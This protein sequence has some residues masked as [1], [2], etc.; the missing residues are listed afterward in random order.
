MKGID[1]LRDLFDE[2]IITIINTFLENPDNPLSLTE[3]SKESGVNV[4]TAL[5]IID[6][7]INKDFVETITIGKSK[8]YKLK[9]SE[10]TLGLYKLLRKDEGLSNFIDKIKQDK[11]IKKIILESKTEKGAKLIIVGSEI[12]TD[13]ILTTA[14]KI[15]RDSKFNIDFIEISEKQFKEMERMGLYNLNKKIV[16]ERA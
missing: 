16:W 4:A 14:N 8:A 1:I 6:K 7:L 10:K 3:I 9:Q 5:R 2:K 13:K 11:R 15:R 12:P